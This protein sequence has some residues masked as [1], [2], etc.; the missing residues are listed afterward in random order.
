MYL[1]RAEALLNGASV[2]GTDALS[3]LNTITS[4]RGASALTAAGMEA[5]RTER[6]KELAWEG[7]YF[8]DLARWGLPVNRAACF[9]LQEKNQ[10]VPFP[11]YR[12]AL[13]LPKT[14]LEVNENLIQ[15]ENY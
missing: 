5:V 9:G 3:D 1:N 13:P 4:H 8:F 6:R 11:D 14:E 15:N 2:S 10:N 12:W 7:H